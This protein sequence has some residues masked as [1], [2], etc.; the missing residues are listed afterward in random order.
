[1]KMKPH[2]ISLLIGIGS[3]DQLKQEGHGDDGDDDIAINAICG[4]VNSM[5]RGGPST[6]RDLRAL[7][8]AL[9][10]MCR[11]FMEKDRS[12]F[13]DAASDACKALQDLRR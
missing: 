5:Y 8:N 9:D 1:M 13:E 3:P 10:N 7:I 12:L 6:V 11:A 4:I 2:G